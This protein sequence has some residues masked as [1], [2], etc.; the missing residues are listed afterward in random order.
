MNLRDVTWLL[1]GVAT[2]VFCIVAG[3]LWGAY[4]EWK[5]VIRTLDEEGYE[6]LGRIIDEHT[7]RR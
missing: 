5:K 2:G 6:K 4:K 3:F 1:V 7:K